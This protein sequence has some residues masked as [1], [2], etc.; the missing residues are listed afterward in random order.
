MTNQILPFF[1]VVFVLVEIFY[2]CKILFVMLLEV[3]HR[4]AFLLVVLSNV[5][6][7]LFKK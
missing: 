7:F 2:P 4:C 3:I 1:C 6:G 5:L